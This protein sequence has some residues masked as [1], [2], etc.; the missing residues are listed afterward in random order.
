MTTTVAPQ[1]TIEYLLLSELAEKFLEGNAKLHDIGAISTSIQ[2]YGFRD[3]LAIDATLNNSKGGIAEGNGRLEALLWMHRQGEKP[4]AYIKLT[5]TGD[6]AIPCIIGGDST[7]EEEGLAYSLDH[8]SLTMTG[9]SFTAL[10]I[11]QLYNPAKYIEVLE[12]LAQSKALPVTV[13][14]DDLDL[15]IG[16]I[17]EGQ[18]QDVE[19]GSNDADKDSEQMPE[20]EINKIPLAIVLTQ[21]ELFEWN[22]DKEKL[23]CAMDSR[24]FREMWRQWKQSFSGRG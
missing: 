4:P 16:M 24:A 15:L 10:D 22:Q 21:E 18:S 19:G 3:P 7:T 5:E 17:G 12:R 14:G 8:N 20:S 6:W 13:D 9:G 11:S 23:G 1:L 2:R